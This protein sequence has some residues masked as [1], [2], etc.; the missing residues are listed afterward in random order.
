MRGCRVRTRRSHPHFLR[1]G[2]LAHQP[3]HGVGCE[4][5][6]HDTVLD[7]VDYDQPAI[8]QLAHAAHERERLGKRRIRLVQLHGLRG[9]E[10]G[11]QY[12]QGG[13]DAHDSLGVGDSRY[14]PL[15]HWNG[16]PP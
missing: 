4:I 11:C 1:T 5:R 14:D 9:R 15:R 2:T 7:P 12:E 3:A 13:K 16:L 6:D 10:R 8:R